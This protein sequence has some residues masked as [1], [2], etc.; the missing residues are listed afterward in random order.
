LNLNAIYNAK[1]PDDFKEFF[2]SFDDFVSSSLTLIAYPLVFIAP[3]HIAYTIY[4]N[5]EKL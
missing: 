4:M 3:M 5:Y 2:G 1:D